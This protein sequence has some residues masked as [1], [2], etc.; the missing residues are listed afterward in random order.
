LKRKKVFDIDI[1][2]LQYGNKTANINTQNFKFK[3]WCKS[4][5]HIQSSTG[6]F[7]RA[8]RMHSAD[9][10]W[11]DVCLSV[12]LSVRHTPVW[13]VNGYTYPQSFISPSGSPTI[14]V[15][16]HQTGW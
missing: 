14:L 10:Q 6:H 9:M 13:C 11:Q 4:K 16:P 12:S 8:S 15:F 5:P 1:Y 7:Y 2:K 3:T